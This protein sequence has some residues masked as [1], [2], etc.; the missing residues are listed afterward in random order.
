MP[1]N[2]L[3]RA[4]LVLTAVGIVSASSV[5][6]ALEES[7]ND[8]PFAV[9]YA[10]Y[11]GLILVA[12][13]RRP[14][15]WGFL[16]AFGLVAITYLMAIV[17]LG[18]NVLAIVFY[19]AVAGLG[20][21]ATPHMFRPL[22]VAAF[23]L[24]TPA[25]RFFGPTPLADGFPPVLAIA[26]I[27]AL[28]NLVAGLLD[29]KA[30]DP[31]ESLRRI[32]LGILA[33]VSVAIVVE[34]HLVVSSRGVAPDDFMALV[35][36]GV[37]PLLA[38]VRLRPEVRD[39]LATGLA[40]AAF[41]LTAM[42]LL[43]GKGY[44]VDA[45]TVPHRAAQELLAGQNPYRAFDLPAALA[46]F[47]IDPQL[48]THYEDGSAVHALN[49]PALSFLVVT[50][51]VAA[52]LTDIRWIY[53]AEVLGMVLILLRRVKI[54]WR[55][56]VAACAVGNTITMRQSILAGV[57]PTW[58][59]LVLISWL[60]VNSRWLSPIALGL[61]VASRQPAWFVVP[62]YVVAIWLRQ[63][64]RK[65]LRRA[66]IV[67]VTALIPNLPFLVDAP[68]AFLDGITGPML[69]AFAPYGVGFVRFGVDGALPLFPREFY[70]ALSA[71]AFVVLIVV[72]VRFWRQ[73]P[74]G[75]LVF[76][77]VP[78]YLAWR[79]LQNYFG[80]VPLLAL[81]GDDEMLIAAP[82]SPDRVATVAAPA[83]TPTPATSRGSP[84]T[85]L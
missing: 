41:S 63:G 21:L 53:L 48:V 25:L 26:S 45:V 42:A 40:L 79:S 51:F 23:A 38:V 5:R 16:L 84:P 27:L 64:P 14:P 71:S 29:R 12:T 7:G 3:L 44:H 22:T 20:C 43:L 47:G 15:R 57:D 77:Y 1:S 58:A 50:P 2:A 70:A 72:L 75:A 52:G 18:G 69:G 73:V 8:L 54:P 28:F 85:G 61:A 10:F 13:P 67:A 31:E 78:L 6:H 83:L 9:G 56:L 46:E 17:A 39:A 37:L 80:S 30:P 4:A 65:A 76:P 68:E 81:A 35:V 33:V 24:W 62:F 82:Q 66:V 60:F 55:P 32:G 34:R 19:V 59:L 74:V 49:Y 36:V 11:L